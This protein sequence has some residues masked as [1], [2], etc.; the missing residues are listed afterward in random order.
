MF[1]IGWAEFFVVILVAV[2]VIPAEK[3]PDVAKALAGL[4]KIVRNL[5]WKITDAGE[6]IKEKIELE[7]PIND[8]IK[9]TTEDV[10]SNFS[11]PISGPKKSISVLKTKNKKTISKPGRKL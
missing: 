7:K 4:V 8:I 2:L 6:Q 5:I 9:N 10:L 11:S 3:W 1:G